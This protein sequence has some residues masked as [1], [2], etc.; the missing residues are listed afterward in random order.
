MP[1]SNNIP[2]GSYLE[3]LKG[4]T[5]FATNAYCF[6]KTPVLF[7]IYAMELYLVEEISLF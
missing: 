6:E 4:K 3:Y 2:L 5:I 7:W 1:L